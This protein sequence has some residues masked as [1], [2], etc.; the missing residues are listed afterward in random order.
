M[1]ALYD[2]AE[3]Y[4]LIEN[5]K[6]TAAIRED[7]RAFLGDRSIRTLPDVSI[8]T[9]GMT[10][11]LREMHRDQRFRPEPGHAGALRRKSPRQG[12]AHR[13]P[14]KRLARAFLPGQGDGLIASPVPA[15]RWVMWKTPGS[16][17]RSN[18]W[19]HR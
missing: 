3:V 6:R 5:E 17:V 19:A 14:P 4:D 1:P 12:K 10:P 11:P 8:G 15:T 13:A 18:R 2:R 16:P 7:L 9:E